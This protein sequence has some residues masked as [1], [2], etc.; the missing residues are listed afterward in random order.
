MPFGYVHNSE[1]TAVEAQRDEYMRKEGEA[2]EK[3]TAFAEKVTV[4]EADVVG[5]KQSNRDFEKITN[6]E[7]TLLHAEQESSL[8]KA[9]QARQFLCGKLGGRLDEG[10]VGA[11]AAADDARAQT[12]P[13]SDSQRMGLT[14]NRAIDHIA[15]IGDRTVRLLE[16]SEQQTKKARSDLAKLKKKALLTD[17]VNKRRARR[18]HDLTIEATNRE[19]SLRA[20]LR[21]R[22]D[23]LRSLRV[24]YKPMVEQMAEMEKTH[25]INIRQHALRVEQLTH[26]AEVAEQRGFDVDTKMK[27]V[28]LK[29]QGAEATI[30][31]QKIERETSAEKKRLGE[32]DDD[33]DEKKSETI[34]KQKLEIE[35]LRKKLKASLARGDYRGSGGRRRF[36]SRHCKASIKA[37]L[38]ELLSAPDEP[39]P[40]VVIDVANV[41]NHGSRK[42]N[43]RFVLQQ[44]IAAFDYYNNPGM[45]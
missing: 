29:H 42:G 18:E 17:E 19:A 2:T 14:I 31:K 30:R 35:A 23:S 38:A 44:V 10:V 24:E 36:R 28:M 41:G 43:R 45:I 26:R 16:T 40:K 7:I 39:S 32:K 25:T 34:R 37:F 11:A 27:K 21:E 3:V 5:L 9:T 4:L 22:S 13:Q 8:Q 6:E 33:D 12:A 15:L 1:V 20:S